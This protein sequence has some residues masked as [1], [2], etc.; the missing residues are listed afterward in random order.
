MSMLLYAEKEFT[1]GLWFTKAVDGIRKTAE[2]HGIALHFISENDIESGVFDKEPRILVVIGAS[3]ILMDRLIAL[4]RKIDVRILFVN[5]ESTTAA[6]EISQVIMDYHDTMERILAYFRDCGM[7]RT[8]LLGVNLDSASDR[9]KA[10]FMKS[11]SNSEKSIFFNDSGITS[12]VEKFITE[13]DSFDSLIFTNDVF[14]LAASAML[15]E[16]GVKIPENLYAVSFSD[17]MLAPI[18]ASPLSPRISTFSIDY[19]ELGRQCAELWYY[20]SRNPADICATIRI[21]ANFTPN[22]STEYRSFPESIPMSAGS[23]AKAYDFYSDKTVSEV[24][25]IESCL[26]QCDE[27]D[28]R[29]LDSLMKGKSRTHIAMELFI[30]EGTLYYRQRKLCK[31]MGVGSVSDLVL[32]LNKYL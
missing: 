22:E 20:L 19:E 3:D 18:F 26:I 9:Q 8:A 13:K 23:V 30:S 1:N 2:K 27:T 10:K 5:Y 6:H 32:L 7:T 28:F 31:L 29:I 21:R 11:H 25:K 14:M 16:A 4:C 12:C 15:R 17:T 24:I